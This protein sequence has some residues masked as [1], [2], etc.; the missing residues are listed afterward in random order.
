MIDISKSKINTFC[1]MSMIIYSE[2]IKGTQNS[3]HR[4]LVLFFYIIPC[5]DESGEGFVVNS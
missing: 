2:R 4:K 1:N 3:P 5:T